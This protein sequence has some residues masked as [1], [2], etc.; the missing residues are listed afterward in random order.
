MHFIIQKGSKYEPNL[1]SSGKA[2]LR[3]KGKFIDRHMRSE[4]ERE[5]ERERDREKRTSQWDFTWNLK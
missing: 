2:A 5:R 3:A 1:Q 4:K